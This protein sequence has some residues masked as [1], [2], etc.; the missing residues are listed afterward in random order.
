[1]KTKLVLLTLVSAFSLACPGQPHA[2]G[3]PCA[4]DEVARRGL[5][6]DWNVPRAAHAD[7]V[8]AVLHQPVRLV[9][10]DDQPDRQFRPRHH[11]L[12]NNVTLDLNGFTLASMAPSATGN[13]IV[14]GMGSGVNGVTI[15]IGFISSGVT[16]NGAGICSGPGFAYGICYGAVAPV[17]VRVSGVSVSGCL[18]HGIFLGSGDTTVVESCTV[19]TAGSYGIC[20]STIKNSVATDCGS[21]AIDGDQVSDSRGESTGD[22]GLS[23][24]IA[25]NCYG[26]SS[27]GTGLYANNNAQN[28]VGLTVGGVAG[29]SAHTAQNCYGYS[30]GGSFSGIS[31]AM[32]NSCYGLS[33]SGTELSATLW[34][35]LLWFLGF[36]NLQI[37]HALSD[38]RFMNPNKPQTMK[39]KFLI[40]ELM[41]FNTA[42]TA[43]AK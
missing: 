35:L 42:S 29:V 39:T 36:R 34:Q 43:S 24:S 9:L 21:V 4:D 13:A 2:A 1:M 37:Q 6:Q 10:S 17:N 27:S 20:A 11:I 18:Y 33:Y 25:Q 12:A 32:A 41:C 28:C 23:A 16:N 5:C 31:A 22:T 3:R 15:V 19:R 30:Y 38:L 26:S 40:F 7:F 14:V 8:R